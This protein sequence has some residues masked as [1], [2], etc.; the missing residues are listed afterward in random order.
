MGAPTQTCTSLWRSGNGQCLECGKFHDY[1]TAKH[2]HRFLYAKAGDT[3]LNC[4]DCHQI[5]FITPEEAAR[6]AGENPPPKPRGLK[7]PELLFA[8]TRGHV[9]PPYVKMARKHTAMW[10]GRYDW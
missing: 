3:M 5:V 7:L 10:A 9:I 4:V 1:I 8:L 2:Q 6:V